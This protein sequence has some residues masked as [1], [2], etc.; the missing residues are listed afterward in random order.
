MPTPLLT[1]GPFA[2]TTADR[3]WVAVGV[4]ELLL[5][6]EGV[7]STLDTRADDL[8]VTL[9]LARAALI[10]VVVPFTLGVGGSDRIFDGV[11]VAVGLGLAGA[12]LVPATR[13]VIG[14]RGVR[15]DGTD[16]FS[17]RWTF[18]DRSDDIGVVVPP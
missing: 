4:P 3:G 12:L 15:L 2:A 14:G 11:R 8:G 17:G 13:G 18:V 16:G 1:P 6:V 10:G 5:G 7:L 9:P